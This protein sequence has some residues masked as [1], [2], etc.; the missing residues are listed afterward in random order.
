MYTL[1][2]GNKNYS[3][4]S[5]RPWVLMRE[6]DI[7]FDEALHVF[8]REE[9]WG[10]YRKTNPSG[11]VPALFHGGSL[12]WDSL[13]I[14]EYLA[15]HHAGVWPSD[16]QTRCWARCAASEMHSGFFELRN[17]CGM[18]CG[19][20]V[21]LS[22]VSPAL[23]RDLTRLDQLWQEGLERF[24]GPFLAGDRFTAVDAFFAP[25]A[26]RI[27]TFGIHLSPAATAYAERLL[28]LDSMRDWYEQAL[29]E[30][31]RDLPH[32]EEVSRVGEIIA[33]LRQDA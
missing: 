16:A 32:E 8:G 3:S 1:H 21:S 2:I 7:P 19:I 22:R 9:D 14:I 15:E 28:E 27:Q 20:R 5:L 12:V 11:L 25:V 30:P 29:R 17:V 31:Y 6:L 18:N 26:F 24:G 13:A 23:S 33:D 10:A 4:W